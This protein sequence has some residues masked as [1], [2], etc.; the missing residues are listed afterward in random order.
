MKKVII[1]TIAQSI[2]FV[3]INTVLGYFFNKPK[4]NFIEYL[5]T[6]TI[7]RI[8][9]FVGLLITNFF[10]NKSELKNR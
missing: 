6:E 8:A 1:T 5:K 3:L 7:Y 4:T 9:A 2:T 10:W